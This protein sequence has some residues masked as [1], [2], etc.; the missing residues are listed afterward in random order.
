MTGAVS[1]LVPTWSHS[2]GA[3]SPTAIQGQA[4][5]IIESAID[6]LLR[7][8]YSNN[9]LQLGFQ[10]GKSTE[11]AILR[12]TELQR[13]GQRCITVLDLSAAYDT[14][15]RELFDKAHEN[16]PASCCVQYGRSIPSAIMD[17]DYRRRGEEVVPGGQRSSSRLTAEPKPL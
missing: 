15:P 14:V 4:R 5:K 16:V 17:I 7:R 2:I 3:D 11:R 8:K 9:V 10:K 1:R 6:I 13:R 12:A